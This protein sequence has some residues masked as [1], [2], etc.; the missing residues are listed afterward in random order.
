MCDVGCLNPNHSSSL[1][2]YRLSDTQGVSVWHTRV[3][4]LH[5]GNSITEHARVS[6]PVHEPKI[7]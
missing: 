2:L 5:A 3:N 7:S 4:M 6:V 1:H